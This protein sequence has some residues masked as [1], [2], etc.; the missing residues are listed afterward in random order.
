MKYLITFFIV[1]LMIS[2][3]CLA[4][5]LRPE[6]YTGEI[7]L[8]DGTTIEYDGLW[9][10]RTMW[11]RFPYSKDIMDMKGSE[12]NAMRLRLSAIS[13]IDFL[14]FTELEKSI[15]E[16]SKLN[17]YLRKAKITF[18]DGVV[19]DKIYLDC[20]GTEWHSYRESGRMRDTRI[21]SVTVNIK[22]AKKCPKCS[23]QFKEKDW[24]FCPYDGS[25]LK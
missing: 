10:W 17:I 7:M 24:K 22:K 3:T 21:A 18:R 9:S 15:I 6:D 1:I 11:D 8:K 16:K 25:P 20:I 12:L 19:Y 14:E 23:R 4:G 13:R 2:S 5:E